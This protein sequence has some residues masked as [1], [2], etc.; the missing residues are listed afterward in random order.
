[1]CS[2]NANIEK[3][4]LNLIKQVRPSVKFKKKL[5]LVD[6]LSF[7]SLDLISFFFEVQSKFE[8]KIPDDDIDKY[9]LFSLDNL[10]SYVEK[11]LS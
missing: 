2:K 10:C 6:D 9:K 8:I 5:N 7:D 3:D 11:K 4:L 1:M